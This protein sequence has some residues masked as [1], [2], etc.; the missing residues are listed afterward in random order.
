MGRGKARTWGAPLTKLKNKWVR[1]RFIVSTTTSNYHQY[2]S[3]R[4]VGT[5]RGGC[6]CTFD[7]G[8]Y[9]T[10]YVPH[11][12]FYVGTVQHTPWEKSFSLANHQSRVWPRER[13]RNYFR[14]KSTARTETLSLKHFWAEFSIPPSRA[15]KRPLFR[16]DSPMMLLTAS[17]CAICGTSTNGLKFGIS[18]SCVLTPAVISNRTE[19]RRQTVR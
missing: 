18:S 10:T 5:G 12:F 3:A 9:L 14:K 11:L 13:R 4:L 16:A 17:S 15:I 8:M 7:F 1:V 6:R 19:S 2:C